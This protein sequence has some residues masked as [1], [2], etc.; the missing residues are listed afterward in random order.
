MSS[1]TAGRAAMRIDPETAWTVVTD[2]PLKGMALA[3]EAGTILA[4]DEGNQLYL[5]DIQGESL[6]CSR[7]PSRILAG[8]IS[9]DGSLVSLLVEGG[10]A[11]LLL[12]DADFTVAHQKPAPSDSAF[13]T[14]DPHGRYVAVGTRH[15]LLH[16]INRYGRPAGRI[17]TVE[18][19][20]H[21]GFVPDRPMAIGAAAMGMMLGVAIDPPRGGGP[22]ETEILWQERM[23]STVGRLTLSGDGGMVLASCYTL[24]IQRFDL[25][26][27][28]EGSYHLGGTVSHAVPDFPGRTIAAATLEGELAIMNSAGN[29]RWRTTLPRPAIALEIDPLGRYV[30]YGHGTGEVVR[31]DLFAGMSPQGAGRRVRRVASASVGTGASAGAGGSRAPAGA[32][33]SPNWVVPAVETDQQAEAGVLA[34]AEESPLIALFTSPQRLH[35]FDTTGERRGQPIE[36]VGGG[37]LLRTTPGWLAAATDRNVVLGDLKRNSFKRLDVN[38]HELT[39]LVIRPDDFGLVLV[40]ER[41]RIGR[42]NTSGRWVWKQELRAPI[43]ELAIGP[44]GF[45]AATTAVGEMRIFDPAGESTTGLTFDPTDPPLLIDAPVDSPPQVAWITLTRRAQLLRGHDLRGQT[46]WERPIPWEGWSLHRLNRSIVATSADGQAIACDGSGDRLFPS[47]STGEVNDQFFVGVDGSPLRLTRKGM[48]LI[49]SS[50]DGRVRW[51]TFLDE[52]PGPIACGPPGIAL[53][54]G[55]SLAWFDESAPA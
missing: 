28:N 31:L 37:R 13:V 2:S 51:R 3:R 52:A 23:M 35:L 25:K 18:T 29:V 19:I 16:L 12:L 46:L 14:I 40:Q 11:E 15:G 10:E 47:V 17:E 4:W 6:S 48:H 55:R 43:E 53:M 24:G 34:V 27:R 5:F 36:V 26:G 39:H 54:L 21:F 45:V 30:I 49:C 38:L 32:V 41:D 7:V 22:L 33:R 20:A 50:L 42:L 44:Y 1:E 8:A 9:D